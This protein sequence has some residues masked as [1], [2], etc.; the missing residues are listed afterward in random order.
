LLDSFLV[1]KG[2]ASRWTFCNWRRGF[3]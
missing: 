1:L 3:V 2:C